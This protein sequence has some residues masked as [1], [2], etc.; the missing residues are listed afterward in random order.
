M[1][2]CSFLVRFSGGEAGDVFAHEELDVYLGA[3][4]RCAEVKDG[5]YYG[6]P[7]L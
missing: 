2:Q 6:F 5:M 1:L 4:S 3:F 7:F